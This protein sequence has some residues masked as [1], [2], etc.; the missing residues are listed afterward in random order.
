MLNFFRR[1]GEVFFAVG[2]GFHPPP[3]VSYLS[4]IRRGTETP[5][6]KT[7]KTV[8]HGIALSSLVGLFILWLCGAAAAEPSV[9]LIAVGDIQLGRGVGEAMQKQDADYPFLKV[10][11]ILRS[12]DIAFGNLE[13]AIS[14]KGR[15]IPKR[16]SFKAAPASLAGVANA[17]FDILSL[18]NNHSL[19]CGR[20]ALPESLAALEKYSLPP[21]GIGNNAQEAAMPLIIEKHGLRIAFLARTMFAPEGVIYREDAPT[22]AMLEPEELIAD[23]KAARKQADLVV[24]SLHWG[25]EYTRQPQEEQRRLAHRLIDAGAGLILGHHPHTP[26]PVERYHRGLIAYSLG[27]FV[28][29]AATPR[30]GKGL[31]LRCVLTKQ[32]AKLVENI[33]IVIKDCQ[34]RMIKN[35]AA[36]GDRPRT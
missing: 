22:V 17:G 13:C 24:V 15:A 11:K 30:A 28:F 9:S 20:S 35:G 10:A 29:D 2:R 27:N 32:G 25:I 36:R 6:Y 5:P 23:V 34:P 31:I 18:A 14:E 3:E 33:P 1:I 26:Q 16:Y 7:S 19:D 12:A 4:P 8:L 21:V